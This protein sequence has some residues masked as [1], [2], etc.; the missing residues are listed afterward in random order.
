[1]I[2]TCVGVSASAEASATTAMRSVGG[3]TSADGCCMLAV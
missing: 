3:N 2:A 1:V